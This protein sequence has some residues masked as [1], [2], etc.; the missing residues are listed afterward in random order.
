MFIEL[1]VIGI[2][3]GVISGFFGVGG[4]TI[5]VP[6]LMYIGID[7]KEAIG[8]SIMQMV[9][10]SYLGSYLNFKK[11]SLQVGSLI[12][13]GYGGLLGALGSGYVVE[14]LSSQVLTIIFMMVVIYA[15]YR[16]FHAPHESDKMP[17]ENK[18]IFFIIGIVIGLLAASVGVGGSIILTPILVGMLH[19]H[20]KSAVAAGLFFVIFSSTAGLISHTLYGNINYEYGLII[21]IASLLGVFLGIHLAHKT[22]PKRHKN[23]IL[24]LNF[25]ILGLI[26]NKLILG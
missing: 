6:L 11:G 26:I 20:I 17:I 4:G 22:D 14:N 25:I 2:F 24:I 9:F 7:I 16:F 3:T 13:I 8:I 15:I 21:G 18:G 10:S 1:A 19:Y 5:L 23:L 12:Y